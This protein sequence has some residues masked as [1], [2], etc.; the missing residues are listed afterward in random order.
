MI[1][2]LCPPRVPLRPLYA[3]GRVHKSLLGT[4]LVT[5]VFASGCSLPPGEDIGADGGFVE[6]PAEQHL[7]TF[8]HG[9]EIDEAGGP[10]LELAS[11]VGEFVVKLVERVGEA[12]PAG[13]QV[14]D[15][16][17]CPWN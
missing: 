16:V 13:V 6:P 8:V 9:R 15:G 11:D 1:A 12:P 5:V 14:G 3:A 17:L 4:L 10:V 2:I 7:T